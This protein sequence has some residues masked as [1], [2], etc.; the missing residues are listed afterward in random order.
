MARIFITSFLSL[1]CGWSCALS[2]E[3]APSPTELSP[4]SVQA[5]LIRKVAPVY[6]PLARQARIQGTVILKIV[7]NKAGDVRDVQLFSG[8]PM[9][10]PAAIE[11][12]KQW[13]YQPYMADGEAIEV[14]TNVRVNFALAGGEPAQKGT[15][16]DSPGGVMG[17]VIGS[18]VGS[19]PGAVLVSEG[20]YRVSEGEMR[21]SR[22]EK[23]DPV[24]P[25]IAIQERI[26]GP[27][28]LDLRIIQT[29]DVEQVS[30]VSGHPMLVSAATEAVKQWKYKPYV[31][32]GTPVVVLTMVRLNFAL[33]ENDTVGTVSEL[34]PSVLMKL[35][36]T[37]ERP[38]PLGGVPRRV[39]VSSGVSQG[40]LVSKVTPEYPPDARDQHIQGVV[41]L[42]VNLDKEGNVYNVELISGHPLLAPAAIDAV[43]QW[44]YRPYLLNGEPVEV[45][46]QVQVNFTLAE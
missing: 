44:K 43:R 12:V 2:Q 28:V 31:K 37:G 21:E 7:I 4:D 34:P 15:V 42:H 46:T 33:S 25:P 20:V 6:P 41:L 36:P 27:V 32:D 40:L 8:H 38:T 22:M 29:G 35:T 17:G 14:T 1:I 3:A 24:Y 11:A 26:Q 23:I 5:L 13:K 39:R 9:L 18:V 16:G 45:D 30:L 19:R 10:A